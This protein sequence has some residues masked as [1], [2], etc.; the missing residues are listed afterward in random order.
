MIIL[1]SFSTRDQIDIDRINKS[2][3]TINKYDGEIQKNSEVVANLSETLKAVEKFANFLGFDISQKLPGMNQIHLFGDIAFEKNAVLLK[4]NLDSVGFVRETFREA[5]IRLQQTNSY[6]EDSFKNYCRIT[7][8]LLHLISYRELYID[9]NKELSCSWIGFSYYIA[10]KSELK[11]NVFNEGITNMTELNI[12]KNFWPDLDLKKYINLKRSELVI[13]DPMSVVLVDLIIDKIAETEKSDYKE[14]LNKLQTFQI[15]NP[16]AG[17]TYL[18][19]RLGKQEVEYLANLKIREIEKAEYYSD[20]EPVYNK[21]G[22]QKQVEVF[23]KDPG[24]RFIEK[25]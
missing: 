23:K 25:L 18:E 24:F 13:G 17:M 20:L 19:S 8:E 2:T 1:P 6:I 10:G 11:F 3:T 4:H 21:L 14:V 15:E 12:V 22:L 7:H 5:L 9:S 16:I